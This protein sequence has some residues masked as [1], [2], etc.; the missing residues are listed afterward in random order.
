M[1]T[2]RRLKI[3]GL[4][5]LSVAG[6]APAEVLAQRY[7]QDEVLE[8]RKKALERRAGGPATVAYPQMS[9]DFLTSLQLLGIRPG[10]TLRE[11]KAAAEKWGAYVT[12]R[13][14]S[15]LQLAR[16]YLT[17]D[18]GDASGGASYFQFTTDAA[19]SYRGAGSVFIPGNERSAMPGGVT[20]QAYPLEPFGDIQDPDKLIVYF[21]QTQLRGGNAGQI[22]EADFVTRGRPLV[23]GTLI[24]RVS[25]RVNYKLCEFADY[26]AQRVLGLSQALD[27]Q[28]QD[29]PSAWAECGDTT[30]VQ[31]N[32]IDAQGLIRG[33][34][35]TR[36]DMTLARK[37]YEVFRQYGS[38]HRAAIY[39][40][41]GKSGD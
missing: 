41:R 40:A 21:V 12:A 25:P 26:H 23:G 14:P 35:V 22:S 2:I 30:V 28:P 13:G 37:A 38:E 24:P 8:A 17:R 3:L 4:V 16:V 11:A 31:F 33:Y 34:S 5:L 15:D 27:L 19:P 10:M 6:V 18:T 7:T 36:F 1:N 20:F 9:T 39:K 32:G 29:R